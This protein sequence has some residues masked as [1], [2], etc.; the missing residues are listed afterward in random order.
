[1]DVADQRVEDRIV[2]DAS[3]IGSI[4]RESTS[5]GLS[6]NKPRTELIATRICPVRWTDT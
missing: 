3:G 2:A 6:I 4:N 5:F 1:M